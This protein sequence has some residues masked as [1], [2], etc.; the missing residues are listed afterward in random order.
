M[1]EKFPIQL[2]QYI[3][4]EGLHAPSENPCP[5]CKGIMTV[6]EEQAGG[7]CTDCYFKYSDHD[8]STGE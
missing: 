7:V 8:S 4:E 3:D 6:G 2:K 1:T 5:T